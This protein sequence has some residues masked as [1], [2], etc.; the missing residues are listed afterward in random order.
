MKQ[1]LAID[2]K[3]DTV[4]AVPLWARDG[5][6]R[7]NTE[8][9]KERVHAGEPK[10]EPI[11]IVGFGPSLNATWKKLKKFKYIISCSGAHKYLLERNIIPTYHVEVDPRPHKAQLI[12]KPHPDVEYLLASCVSPKVIDL[13]DG[14]NVKLWHV[15][16]QDGESEQVIPRGDFQMLGGCDV[17]MRCMTLARFLGFTDMHIFGL[18]GCEGPSGKHAAFH[19]NQPKNHSIV[20]H[21]GKKYKTTPAM[22]ASAQQ[23]F[24]EL[25]RMPD[26]TAKFYGTGLIQAMA[27]T[28]VRKAVNPDPIAFTKPELISVE[29]RDLNAQ[30]HRE[31]VAYGVGGGKHANTVKQLAESMK[32]TSVLDYGAGKQMLAKALPF[33]IWS[34]DP[35][36]PAISEAPRPA[37]IVVCTDVLEHIEP[38]RLDFVLKDLKR[39][40]LKIG[41][42]VI[43]MGPA[44]KTLPDGRNTHLIQKDK[45]WWRNNLAQN[46]S[47]AKI[48][49]RGIELHVVVGPKQ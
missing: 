40:V 35:A 38:D 18:D 34:Y 48:F 42:F 3:P 5:Q 4:Y 23:V 21:E 11:A 41:Y 6:I 7:V 16:S 36:V 14:F 1:A 17:G 29:Y 31:N 32:T 13:V 46:F 47:V 25:D 37:D 20:E 24:H 45:V 22:L 8:R 2:K 33:P 26:V 49:T 12:G 27:K 30:L 10:D 39:V 43:H 9:V 44:S 19:P 15:F 28:Y